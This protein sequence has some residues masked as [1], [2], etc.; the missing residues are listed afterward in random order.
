MTSP[1]T[2]EQFIEEQVARV[3]PLDKALSL[4]YW[5][6]TTTG[7]QEYAEEVTRLQ[8]ALR[9]IYADRARFDRLTALMDAGPIAD[10]LLARQALLLRHAFTGNQMDDA[11][12]EE[13][14]RREVDIESTFNTFRA[15]LRGKQAS[16]NE[17]KEV[18][19]Q[20]DDVALRREAWEA[21]KQIGAE[22]AGRLVELVELRNDI[23]RSIGFENHFRM[24]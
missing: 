2:M 21:S 4:A 17:I 12:I 23:A 5:N 3:E 15:E 14:T 6:F 11:T 22:V 19:R 7:K 20:S 18:L 13:L 10:P 9:K 24:G 1:E 8:V 16:E